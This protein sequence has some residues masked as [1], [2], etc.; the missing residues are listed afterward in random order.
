MEIFEVLEKSPGA[1][2]F[3]VV[4]LGLCVGSLLNVVIHR[5]PRIMESRGGARGAPS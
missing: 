2:L 3:A 5:M 1:L 4:L